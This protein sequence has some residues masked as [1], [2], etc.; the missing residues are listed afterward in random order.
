M[1]NPQGHGGEKAFLIL[2]SLAV[3][4]VFGVRRAIDFGG[5]MIS[6]RPDGIVTGL[7]LTAAVALAYTMVAGIGISIYEGMKSIAYRGQM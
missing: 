2:A 6:L 7:I 5:P 3:G 1:H 4:L